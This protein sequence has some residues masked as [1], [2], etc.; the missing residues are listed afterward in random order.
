M[1][2]IP[3]VIEIE[4]LVSMTAVGQS[5]ADAAKKG[6]LNLPKD[7]Q[8]PCVLGYLDP[9]NISLLEWEL[10]GLRE[11]LGE[12]DPGSLEGVEELGRGYPWCAV[13]IKE[14]QAFFG[15]KASKPYL[16]GDYTFVPIVGSVPSHTDE[17]LGW[18]LNWMP[19]AR[20]ASNTIGGI[21]MKDEDPELITSSSARKNSKPFF[22]KPGA[23]FIF[24]AEE[25][26][27]W[28]YNGQAVLI[29][30]TIAAVVSENK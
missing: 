5:F 10:K 12:C 13:L 19:F 26:H 7:G 15:L 11:A 18:L 3:S 8:A 30:G 21:S 9:R 1:T 16:Y 27:A 25:Y 14:L 4:K 17:G 24:N 29:Q 2:E 20:E 28:L 6:T 23:I 22:I